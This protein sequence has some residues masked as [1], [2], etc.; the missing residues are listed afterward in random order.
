MGRRFAVVLLA[1]SSA[2]MFPEQDFVA[3]GF[4]TPVGP[5][6]IRIGTRH[7]DEGFEAP[8]PRELL[9]EIKGEAP[10]LDDAVVHFPWAG[11]PF[12]PMLA[13]AANTAVDPLETWLAL[14]VSDGIRDRAF[15][16]TD[17][18]L[19]SGLPRQGRHVDGVSTAA[20]LAAF[21][22]NTNAPVLGR[23]AGQYALALDYWFFGGE[24]LAL[25]HLYIAVG[26]V[27]KA[28]VAQECRR[29]GLTE[30]QL[31]RREGVRKRHLHAH[32]RRKSIFRGDDETYESV[33]KASDSFE[34]GS[35]SMAEIHDVSREFCEK[36]FAYVREA[37]LR[38]F[39]LDDAHY[40]TLTQGLWARPLDVKS[41]RRVVRATLVSDMQLESLALPGEP[42]PRLKW[43]SVVKGLV[44]DAEGLHIQLAERFPPHTS[45]MEFQNFQVEL[46]YRDPG[47]E[48]SEDIHEI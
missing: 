38:S 37:I 9:V 7:T 14:E 44:R 46:R 5:V 36:A 1:G 3:E 25:A 48:S 12:G 6:V 42:Y 31:A 24:T 4:E 11:R 10:T 15:L 21:G 18:A 28:V 29:S 16:Q 30:D 17:F 13:L 19:E 43:D 8:V 47:D 40:R 22:M 26:S 35:G 45:G 39:E 34:H 41:L 27:E 2:R 20:L 32:M 33:R 23:A